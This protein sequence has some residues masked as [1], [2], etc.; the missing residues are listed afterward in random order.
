MKVNLSECSEM[1]DNLSEG[2]FTHSWDDC[3][4]EDYVELVNCDYDNDQYENHRR[5][6]HI[7]NISSDHTNDSDFGQ[8]F[9]WNDEDEIPEVGFRSH[10]SGYS[11]SEESD[12]VSEMLDEQLFQDDDDSEL[13]EVQYFW[14]SSVSCGDAF[15]SAFEEL[16]EQSGWGDDIYFTAI[17]G[18]V[19]VPLDSFSKPTNI[20]SDFGPY[21]GIDGWSRNDYGENFDDD[22]NEINAML[23]RLT[24]VADEPENEEENLYMRCRKDARKMDSAATRHLTKGIKACLRGDDIAANR[25]LEKFKEEEKAARRLHAEAAREIL[26]IMNKN[27]GIMKLDLHYL[28]VAE[29]IQA[30]KERLHKIETKRYLI[31]SEEDEWGNLYQPLLEVIT[32]RG[33]HSSGPPK[34]PGAVRSF[35]VKNGYHFDGSR[36]GVIMVHPKVSCQDDDGY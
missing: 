24:C 15:D 14:E 33:K 34:L 16:N 19:D 35:L 32:G 18:T 31:C 3:S 10:Q 17:A 2:D 21:D 30:V 36:P 9:H 25:Y 27:N 20:G 23:R 29:A 7:R 6:C 13:S 1:S 11:S 8:Q 12:Q 28:H 22:V 4:W 26:S 5:S